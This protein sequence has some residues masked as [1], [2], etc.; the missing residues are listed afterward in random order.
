MAAGATASKHLMFVY[1]TLKRGFPNHQHMPVGIEFVSRATTVERFPLV[2]GA[3]HNQIP[4]LLDFAG[5]GFQV[6]GEV[7]VADDA[8]CNALDVRLS[9]PSGLWL[10]F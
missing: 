10:P 7:F 2:V 9:L 4:F 6:N 3:G 1:G 5:N 8:A